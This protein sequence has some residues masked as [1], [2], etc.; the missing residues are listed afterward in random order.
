MN[1]RLTLVLLAFFTLVPVMGADPSPAQ[2]GGIDGKA[3]VIPDT[4]PEAWEP[5]VKWV[6][7]RLRVNDEHG[8]G[9]DV[10]SDEWAGAVGKWLELDA[11]DAGHPDL[12]SQVWRKEVEKRLGWNP[13]SPGESRALLSSHDV[14]ARFVGITEHRCR[15]LTALCPDR[16][17]H[18]GQLAT[19]AI[20]KYLF[21]QKPGPYGDEKQERFLVLIENHVNPPHLPDA[22]RKQILALKPGAS[23]R[24]QWVHDYVTREGS[25]FPD[26]PITSLRVLQLTP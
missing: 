8:H 11:G 22:I 15:G 19:F 12:K 26:R 16:C 5:W 3:S 1:A 20:E 7:A 21:H 17:G 13:T 6:D 9:P 18:S 14:I 25:K 10:G 24:L 23:V 4:P 2:A